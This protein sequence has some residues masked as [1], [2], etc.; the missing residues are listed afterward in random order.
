MEESIT[1][2]INAN[3]IQNK[4]LGSYIQQISKATL[5]LQSQAYKIAAI[6]AKIQEEQ[7]WQDDFESFDDFGLQIMGVKKGTLY[8]MAKLGSK[9]TD[10]KGH[11][12]LYTGE[13]D[14]T[15]SQMYVLMRVKMPKGNDPVELVKKWNEDG[16]INPLMSC[17]ELKEVVDAYNEQ[18]KKPKEL[19]E[20]SEI[21]DEKEVVTEV[22]ANIEKVEH[23]LEWLHLGASFTIEFDG[24]AMKVDEKKWLDLLNAVTEI[25]NV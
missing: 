3:E 10:G 6:V 9:W 4:K 14:Y 11:S 5:S 7:V 25:I 2:V 8:N 21:G 16:I 1:K 22:E 24:K 17:K 23:T 18:F 15:T 20:G 13:P 19:K 12:V